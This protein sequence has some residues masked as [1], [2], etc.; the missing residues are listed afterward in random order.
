MYILR[1]YVR[2]RSSIC[3]PSSAIAAVHR[4]MSE[5]RCTNK[6]KEKEGLGIK[7][8]KKKNIKKEKTG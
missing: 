2:T 1:R 5:A 3:I 6:E 7:Q 4:V 8:H